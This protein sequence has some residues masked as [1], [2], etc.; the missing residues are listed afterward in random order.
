[1][2]ELFAN[3]TSTIL[4][5]FVELCEDPIPNDDESNCIVWSLY[6]LDSFVVKA[7]FEIGFP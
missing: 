6:V 7:D 5:I 2:P 4:F 3:A 1:M